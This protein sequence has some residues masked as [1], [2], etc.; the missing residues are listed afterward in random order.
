MPIHIGDEVSS[1]SAILL[2]EEYYKFL[3][4]NR[5]SAGGVAV[6]SVEGLIPFK[7]KAWLDLSAK[8]ADGKAVPRQS[9]TSETIASS[10]GE[11]SHT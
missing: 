6:L 1:L 5:V 9:D 4:E 3:V 7:A 8:R 11:F 2:D 10:V